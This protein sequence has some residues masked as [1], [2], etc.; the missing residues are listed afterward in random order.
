MRHFFCDD[1]EETKAVTLVG[2]PDRGLSF[3]RS[4]YAPCGWL[5]RHVVVLHMIV[6]HD[7]NGGLSSS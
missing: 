7:D 1:S 2:N 5:G 6:F 4:M 3:W